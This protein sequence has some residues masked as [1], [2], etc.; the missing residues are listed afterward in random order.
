MSA[1]TRKAA[2]RKRAKHEAEAAFTDAEAAIIK[3]AALG[4]YHNWTIISADETNKRLLC[5][6]RCGVTRAIAIDSLK[7]GDAARSCGACTNRYDPAI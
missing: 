4:S 6:C 2:K 5:R 3:L 1:K 7:S